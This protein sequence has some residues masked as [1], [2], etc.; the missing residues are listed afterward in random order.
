LVVI[1]NVQWNDAIFF[2]KS[3][4]CE[5]SYHFEWSH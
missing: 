5:Y 3:V 2:L 4:Y 1:E